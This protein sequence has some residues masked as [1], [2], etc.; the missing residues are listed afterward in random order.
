MLYNRTFCQSTG[1]SENLMLK[2]ATR[3]IA[4]VLTGGV[5][6]SAADVQRKNDPAFNQVIQTIFAARGFDQTAIS[7][8]GRQ[9]AW[10]EKLVDKSGVPNRKMS[11]YVSAIQGGTAARRITAGNRINSYVEHAIAWS[12]DSKQL[13]FLSDASTPGQA[14]LYITDVATGRTHKLTEVKGSLDGPRWSPEGK[15]LAVLFTENATRAAGPLVAETPQTGVIREAVTEQRLAVVGV[16]GG[17]LRQISPAD[18]YVY[19]YDWSPDG[20]QFVV[21]AAHGNG[22]DNWYIAQLYTLD[23]SGG[24]MKSIFK[25]SLQ[26]AVPAWSPDGKSV[27]FIAGLMSDEPSVGGD[28]FLVS[29]QGGDARNLT[30]DLKASASWLTWTQDGKILFGEWVDGGAAIATLDPESA[31]P[32]VLWKSDDQIT[33]NGWGAAVSLAAD[34]KTAAMIRQS[35]QR[36]PEVW[37]GPIGDWKQITARNANLRPAWGQTKSIHWRNE[38]FDLQGWLLYPWNFDPK[39]KYPMVV[40]VHGGPGSMAHLS[41]P[42]P[43]SF[44]V[45]LSGA[46]YFVFFPNPRG[47][48]GEG[49]TFTRANVKD[50]GYGDWRDILAGVD[51][52][53]KE[54]PIDEHRLGLTGWSYGGYMTMWGVT[55]THRFAAAAAGAGL[56][57]LQS[58]YGENQIDQWM[59]PFFG[60]SVYDDPAVYAKSSPISFIKNA[61]TPTLILVGDS[62]GECPTPQS[63]EFWHA[64][65]TLGVEN[66]FVVYEHEGHDFANPVHQRDV[67]ERVAGWFDRHLK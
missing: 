25:P 29:A 5:W 15:S 40:S 47:S 34:G 42:S 64:L 16:S 26:I 46:G 63:Y 13:A 37:A 43:H 28:I 3:I 61:K 31:K 22:D 18:M 56:A 53:L 44:A 35:L 20:R 21:T 8:D 51:A 11:I 27:A 48:F 45:A 65:Q 14:Q 17:S 41:W 66:E 2:V 7:P 50:F 1:F 52:A 38:G 12:P 39:Q 57:N 67:I 60:A 24:E 23:V 4:V 55:Q 9:V 30:P 59:I 54:A 32:E 49:E 6:A 58:Y 33:A 36:P 19:E 62:D 10:V